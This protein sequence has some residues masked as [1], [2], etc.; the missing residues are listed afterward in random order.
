MCLVKHLTCFF[1]RCRGALTTD[2]RRTAKLIRRFE[3]AAS[4][5]LGVLSDNEQTTRRKGLESKSRL[6][7]RLICMHKLS[8]LS[9]DT[10]ERKFGKISTDTS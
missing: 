10:N 9:V 3:G 1:F 6:K 8:S 5:F 4:A 7:D 2:S